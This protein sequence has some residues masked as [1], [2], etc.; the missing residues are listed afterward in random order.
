M[1]LGKKTLTYIWEISHMVAFI[2][3][4]QFLDLGFLC[5]DSCGVGL[6]LGMMAVTA[7]VDFRS[8]SEKFLLNVSHFQAPVS[9][10]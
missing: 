4:G 5:T 9:T 10:S 3:L 6:I 2:F 1:D 8:V 7:V